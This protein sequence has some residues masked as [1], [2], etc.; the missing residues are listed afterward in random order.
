MSSPLRC[1]GLV[2][3]RGG[4]PGGE[5]AVP[6]NVPALMMIG[7]FDEFGGTLRNEAGR[8]TWEGGRDAL[9]AIVGDNNGGRPSEDWGKTSV[10]DRL[11]LAPARKSVTLPIAEENKVR[12]QRARM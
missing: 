2:Q 6:P 10:S 3:Y 9:A 4:V 11:V 8:E 12:F 7:Q 5:E 1:F